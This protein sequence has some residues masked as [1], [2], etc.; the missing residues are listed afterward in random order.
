MK[1]YIELCD[2]C[3]ADGES[4]I[5]KNGY[6]GDGGAEYHCCDEHL[7]TVRKAELDNWEL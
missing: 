3:L 5:A 2:I 6:N 1:K 7:D 4:V